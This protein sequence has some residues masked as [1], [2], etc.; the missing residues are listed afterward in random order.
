MTAGEAVAPGSLIDLTATIVSHAGGGREAPPVAG[1]PAGAAGARLRLLE[2]GRLLEARPFTGAGRGDTG[3]RAVSRAGRS[4]QAQ[5]S[6]PSRLPEDAE[7]AVPGNNRRSVLRAAR[8][9]A[10]AAS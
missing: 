6:T 10:S 1:A 7:D 5:L 3:R 4:G 2:D 8:H 9:A